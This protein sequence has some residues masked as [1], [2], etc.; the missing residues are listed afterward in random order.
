MDR[1]QDDFVFGFDATRD[2]PLSLQWGGVTDENLHALRLLHHDYSETLRRMLAQLI[3]MG[4]H[5]PDQS[6]SYSRN[7]NH[8]TGRKR[9]EGQYYSHDRVIGSVA[10]L[11]ELGMVEEQRA[12]PGSH[13]IQS[14]I[15]ASRDLIEWTR[16]WGP[17]FP[18]LLACIHLKNAD[19]KRI[20]Y[21]DD[22]V[23]RQMRGEMENINSALLGVEIDFDQSIHPLDFT[24]PLVRL[25]KQY[26]APYAKQLFRSF[27]IDFDH[28]GRAY[29]GFWQNMRSDDRREERGEERAGQGVEVGAISMDFGR[30]FVGSSPSGIDQ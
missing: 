7:T 21:V 5:A 4:R 12:K 3:V 25:G 16:D 18:Q 8:Y 9:Y 2:I 17:F 26:F 23:T 10:I 30:N 11:R 22:E 27:N 6:I 29:G 15:R 19:K 24:L 14:C 28:G 20:N 13:G 1:D